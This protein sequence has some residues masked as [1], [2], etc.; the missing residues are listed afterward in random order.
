MDCEV[1]QFPTG[2]FAG[3]PRGLSVSTMRFRRRAYLSE[4]IG[5]I[6]SYER[7]FKMSNK[8]RVVGTLTQDRMSAVG[9][10]IGPV[11]N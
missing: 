3:K 4:I 1:F 7:S 5:V 11:P 2:T 8:G 9:G 10:L 6:S